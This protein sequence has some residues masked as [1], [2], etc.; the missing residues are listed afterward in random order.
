VGRVPRIVKADGP[1]QPSKGAVGAAQ[2]DPEDLDLADHV[3]S[4]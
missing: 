2:L 1:L 4:L 3:E